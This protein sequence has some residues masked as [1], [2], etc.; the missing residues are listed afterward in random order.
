M[1]NGDLDGHACSVAVSYAPNSYDLYILG[2]TF[3]RNFVSTYDY[4]AK[5][6]RLAINANAPNGTDALAIAS[7]MT[8]TTDM[9]YIIGGGIAAVLL[10]C[11]LCKICSSDDK[12]K[13]KKKRKDEEERLNSS[14][15]ASSGSSD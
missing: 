10:I 14:A 2:D 5:K 8:L 3:L 12:K 13:K 9:M 7:P 1:S 4:K 15:S 6:V 11:C